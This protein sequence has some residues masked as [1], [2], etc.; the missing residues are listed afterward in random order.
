MTARTF[1]PNGLCCSY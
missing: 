1:N